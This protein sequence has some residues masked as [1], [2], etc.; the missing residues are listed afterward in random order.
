MHDTENALFSVNPDPF[1]LILLTFLGESL[2]L[3]LFMLIQ[4]SVSVSF[5]NK[6]SLDQ[7]VFYFATIHFCVYYV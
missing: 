5:R 4:A 7:L 1:I 2:L 6:I 3:L